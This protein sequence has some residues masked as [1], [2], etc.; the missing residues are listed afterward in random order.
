MQAVGPAKV[1]PADCFAIVSY[2]PD[3]LGG[4]LDNLRKSLWV[5]DQSRAHLTLLPPRPLPLS[6]ESIGQLVRPILRSFRRFKVELTD[7]AV[8][9]TEIL[10]LQ[11]GQGMEELEELHAKLNSGALSH[12]EAF[13]FLPHSTLSPPLQGERLR[14][15]LAQANRAWSDYR[16]E[17][18]YT[19]ESL[20]LVQQK[21]DG[22]WYRM[23]EEPVNG[24]V[25]RNRC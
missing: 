9:P 11:V 5:N 17:R 22:N 14:A 21:E 25:A 2:I 24:A 8:F 12:P 10:Y 23:W 7:I 16:F 3:P 20:T 4:F 18:H 15:G 19:M 6:P 13:E 1:A